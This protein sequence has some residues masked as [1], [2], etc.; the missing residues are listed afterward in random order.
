[1][2]L[3]C[4]IPTYN[5]RAGLEGTLGNLLGQTRKPDEIIVVDNGST[6][7]TEGVKERFP[8]RYIRLEENTGSA[9][10]YYEG[11]KAAA[12]ADLIFLSDDDNLYRPDA[13]ERLEAG[14]LELIASGKAGAVRCAWDGFEGNVPQ[15]VDNSMWSGTLVSGEAAR[16]TGLPLKELFLYAEDLEYFLRLRKAGFSIY[17]LPLAGY[18]R[19]P[20]Q[21]K[22]IINLPFRPAL[23]YREDF[24]LY[25]AFRNEL[26]IG[27][28]HGLGNT[29][30]L[31]L[32]F[33]KIAPFIGPSAALACVDGIIDGFKGRLGKNERYAVKR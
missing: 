28:L 9:G 10:G 17:V 5:N 27:R 31:L 8:V 4:V 20:A 30:R 16:R 22:R 19:R 33:L 6:D 24:R 1:M 11:I 13:L 32:Y 12:H 25:Y 18:L 2:K 21:H 7:G 23:V 15:A 14:L 3:C 26:Y 29:V